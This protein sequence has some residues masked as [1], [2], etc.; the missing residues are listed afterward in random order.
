MTQGVKL[1]QGSRCTWQSGSLRQMYHCRP[2]SQVNMGDTATVDTPACKLVHIAL[3]IRPCVVLGARRVGRCS[4]LS[5]TRFTRCCCHGRWRVEDD[6][7]R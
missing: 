6:R 1:L 7:H 4:Q 2:E 3:S 5:C